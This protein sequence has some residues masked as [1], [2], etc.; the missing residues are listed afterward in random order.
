MREVKPKNMNTRTVQIFITDK[1]KIEK[2]ED[3]YSGEP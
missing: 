2:N 1:L 3:V